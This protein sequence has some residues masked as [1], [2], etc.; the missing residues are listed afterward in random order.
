VAEDSRMTNKKKNKKVL[1]KVKDL[2]EDQLDKAID[3][4]LDLL[5]GLDDQDDAKENKL[6]ATKAQTKKIKPAKSSKKK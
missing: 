2:N 6:S 4:A 3:S 1:V 5:F